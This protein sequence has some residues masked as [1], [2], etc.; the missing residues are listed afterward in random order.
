MK[1]IGL[2]RAMQCHF[3]AGRD[4]F[5]FYNARRDAVCFSR[6]GD[7]AA[8]LRAVGVM[9]RVVEREIPLTRR[10]KSLCLADS[11]L[12]FH[13]EAEGYLCHPE[14]FDWRIPTLERSLGRLD[15]IEAEIRAGRGYPLSPLE[16][17]APVFPAK[18]DENGDLVLE[19]E[20]KGSGTV[21]LWLYDL[22]G[23]Q[24]ARRY[25]VEPSGGRFSLAI[26]PSA[27]DGDPRLRPAWLQIHQGCSYFGDSW[28]WPAHPPFKW[29][30]KQRDL[31]GFHSARIVVK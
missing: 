7:P 10:M 16:K 11:R 22:C 29:R 15:E 23:T 17:A 21:T 24:P 30:W 8:A 28:Q 1:E 13:S 6:A 2:V 12:G 14:Y 5:E 31:L 26:P 20:A 19:G 9:K 4:F 3:A 25:D 27:W 18:L